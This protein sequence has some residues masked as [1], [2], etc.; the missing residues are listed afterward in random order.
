ME[1]EFRYIP[2]DEQIV[3]NE[4]KEEANLWYRGLPC[5]T[6]ELVYCIGLEQVNQI[7]QQIKQ[8]IQWRMSMF[9]KPSKKN[10]LPKTLMF[11]NRSDH[12]DTTK[13]TTGVFCKSNIDSVLDQ[14]LTKSQLESKYYFPE[15]LF[16]EGN[17][18][19]EVL[20]I[21]DWIKTAIAQV[22]LGFI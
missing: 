18:V 19:M 10:F 14:D 3:E 9:G 5:P 21:H 2:D 8:M 13:V 1:D 17:Y 6:N 12:R 4:W 16:D 20:E 7:D 11:Y 22:E 15:R